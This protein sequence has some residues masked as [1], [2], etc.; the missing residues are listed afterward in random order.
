MSTHCNAD[1]VSRSTGRRPRRAKG[2]APISLPDTAKD[3]RTWSRDALMT[4]NDLR[5]WVAMKVTYGL[6]TRGSVIGGESIAL[7][8]S[9]VVYQRGIF[10]APVA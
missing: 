10:T 7:R 4:R 9:A 1:G 6:F 8:A 3:S 5:P 2:P